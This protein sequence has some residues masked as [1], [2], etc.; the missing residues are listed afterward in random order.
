MHFVVADNWLV[1][2]SGGRQTETSSVDQAREARH[3]SINRWT[4]APW[5]PI[6]FVAAARQ[7]KKGHQTKSQWIF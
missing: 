7:Q 4:E 3:L 1:Q 2:K 5:Y 6:G